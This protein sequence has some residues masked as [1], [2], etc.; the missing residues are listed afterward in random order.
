MHAMRP[1]PPVLV[2]SLLLALAACQDPEVAP[3]PSR[4]NPN[5]LARVSGTLSLE[6]TANAGGVQVALSGTQLH[7]TTN[8]AGAFVLENVPPGTHELTA[9]HT[10]YTQTRRSLSVGEGERVEVSLALLRTRGRVDGVLQ[11]DDATAVSG[12]EVRLEGMDKATHSDADGRFALE[13][14]P[15]GSHVLVALKP[16]YMT[17]RETV[18]VKEAVST[19]VTLTL[20]RSRGRVEGVV[21]LDDTQDLAGTQV[22]LFDWNAGP[23]TTDAEGRF[24][25]EGVPTGS[26][27]VRVTR[28]GYKAPL[29]PQV[30]VRANATT[31]LSM[32]LERRTG[33]IQGRVTLEGRTNNHAG[34]RIG[35]AGRTDA[36]TTNVAG[37]FQFTHLPPGDYSLQ[38][39]LSQY[40]TVNLPV[41]VSPDETRDLHITMKLARGEV[42]GIVRLEDASDG[43]HGGTW[44]TL[45]GISLYA[46]TG[47]DGS[48]TF[49]N[50]PVGTYPVRA[51]RD[52]YAE[53]SVRVSVVANQSA[54]VTLTLPRLRGEVSGQVVLSDG[55]ALSGIS[56]FQSGLATPITPDAQGRFS[57]VGLP[58]GT[59]SLKALKEGYAKAEQSVTVHDHRTTDVSLR[60][61]RMPPPT[62]T[63]L[64]FLAVQGGWMTLTGTN[65]GE[66]PG[67]SQ[68]TVG[69]ST[70]A[71]IISWSQ[72]RAVVRMP[73]EVPPGVQQVVLKTG[74]PQQTLTAQVRV[75][76]Q[77]TLAIG[78]AW[79]LGV[80]PD[81][82][83]QHLA[84]NSVWGN[85]PASL[86]QGIV[87]VAADDAYGMVLKEDGTVDWWGYNFDHVGDPPRGLSGVVAISTGHGFAV[88]LKNDGTLV[89]WGSVDSPA[90]KAP[91]GVTDVI[92]IS[93][94]RNHALALRADGTVI[95]WGYNGHGGATVPEG[96][97]NVVELSAGISSSVARKADGSLIAWGTL[98][99]ERPL[100]QGL[101]GVRTLAL[102]RTD[103]HGLAV[104]SEEQVIAWG[105][106]TTNLN[107]S[108]NGL[109][110]P[111]QTQVVTVAMGLYRADAVLHADGTL[112]I[113]GVSSEGMNTL[114]AGKVLRVPAR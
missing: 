92:A 21:R 77:T 111:V 48:F 30:E 72:T 88:A 80:L 53:R 35:I 66:E 75:V 112:T 64:P 17:A 96:L 34:V 36:V 28:D 19:S 73:Y 84:Q 49:E 87:S 107:G 45:E 27:R 22:S 100:P 3:T 59:Y 93:A 83:V 79:G 20:A 38:A 95:A 82:T 24:V 104:L 32:T 5:G 52:T 113:W 26:Y 60:L 109:P 41:K 46:F 39:T 68:V 91:A 25:L 110:P 74:V 61:T 1:S 44:V 18:E 86:N 98:S 71:K 42:K 89:A 56:V 102:G 106:S 114:P 2:L 101:T 6:G 12:L 85:S 108:R 54:S 16:G 43:N 76:S 31:T 50:V 90:A 69:A 10:G 47:A 51:S 40:E 103:N 94:G 58:V 4:P 57:L 63:S 33:A 23:T 9:T 65:L 97:T 67:G 7:A 99:P 81:A 11:L 8:T 55:G 105:E 13:D 70:P 14:V 62:L 78:S 15:T 37:D 29:P